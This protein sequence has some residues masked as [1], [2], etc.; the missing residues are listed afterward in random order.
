VI[1]AIAGVVLTV[2]VVAVSVLAARPPGGPSSTG[3]RATANNSAAAT[4]HPPPRSASQY[5]ASPQILSNCRW[6][7]GSRIFA[8]KSA[9]TCNPV[10]S[11]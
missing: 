6:S 10:P 5:W 9:R 1:A 8:S 4:R 11:P 2:A 3:H 7:R